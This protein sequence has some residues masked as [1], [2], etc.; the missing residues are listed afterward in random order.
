MLLLQFST[1]HYCRK[2]RLA[3]GYKG[4]AYQV[5]NLTPGLHALQLRPLTGLTTV[6]V[7]LPQI[8]GQPEFIADSSHIFRYLERYQPDPPLFLSNPE[9][10]HQA[11]LLEDW[12]DESIGTATRFVYYHFRAG[13]GK[14]LDP[15]LPSQ[16]V[17]N[18]V[19]A[20]YGINAASV[21]LAE[22]RLAL[23]LRVLAP[24]QDRPYLCSDQISIADVTAA[25]LL[26]PLARIPD[27]R[28]NY[29]WLFQRIGEIHQQC[30]E[31]LP[32]GLE[33]SKGDL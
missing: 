1:S 14:A 26:S 2:A 13:E 31:P 17:I 12:L 32:P 20:Q 23:A 10:Q 30:R 28:D 33:A 6:P 15:S 24:W 27:Y 16:I 4:L 25:A 8:A 9:H 5:R 3:L 11:E 29:P 21:A 7:L 19:R 18:I 22:E